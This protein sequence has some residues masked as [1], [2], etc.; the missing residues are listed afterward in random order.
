M[1]HSILLETCAAM[2][3]REQSF[4]LHSRLWILRPALGFWMQGLGLRKL[5]FKPKPIFGFCNLGLNQTVKFR[6]AVRMLS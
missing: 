4:V 1:Q 3:K 2:A 6:N 5:G